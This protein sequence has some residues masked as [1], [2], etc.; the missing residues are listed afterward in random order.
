MYL[1][2]LVQEMAAESRM[3]RSLLK[4]VKCVFVFVFTLQPHILEEVSLSE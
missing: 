1:H 4:F 3:R 2:L